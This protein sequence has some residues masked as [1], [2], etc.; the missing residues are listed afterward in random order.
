MVE[1][2]KSQCLSSDLLYVWHIHTHVHIR[3]IGRLPTAKLITFYIL[4]VF[5]EVLRE[6]TG[7]FHSLMHDIDTLILH[8]S[9]CITRMSFR[10]AS[11]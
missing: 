8:V 7:C 1:G 10:P 11:P 6:M 9:F 4:L 2:F 5:P 3:A